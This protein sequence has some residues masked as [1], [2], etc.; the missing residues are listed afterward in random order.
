MSLQ[1]EINEREAAAAHDDAN[2]R[3]EARETA[4]RIANDVQ[5]LMA[6]AETIFLRWAD[7]GLLDQTHKDVQYDHSVGRNVLVELPRLSPL[8]ASARWARVVRGVAED[9]LSVS[10]REAVDAQ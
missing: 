4:A 1:A 8:A 5:E 9:A 10:A 3:M 6:V 7:D 2:W